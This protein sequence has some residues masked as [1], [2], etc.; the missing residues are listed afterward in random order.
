MLTRL[1]ANAWAHIQTWDQVDLVC[2][3]GG[4]E[5]FNPAKQKLPRM[6]QE[7]EWEKVSSQGTDGIQ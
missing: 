5:S 6:L 2:G 3:A 4:V 1:N 7:H